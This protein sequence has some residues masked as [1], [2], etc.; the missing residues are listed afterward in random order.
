M[1]EGFRVPTIENF[2][3]LGL[4]LLIMM[5]ILTADASQLRCKFIRYD[6]YSNQLYY[7]K[8]SSITNT[9]G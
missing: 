4:N 8:Q 9:T 1:Y 3:P 2:E 5:T 6:S 7:H